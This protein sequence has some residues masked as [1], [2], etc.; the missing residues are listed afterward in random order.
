MSEQIPAHPCFICGLPTEEQTIC[1][2]CQRDPEAFEKYQERMQTLVDKV[3][4]TG[5]IPSLVPPNATGSTYCARHK[6]KYMIKYGCSQC[7]KEGQ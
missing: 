5:E 6:I 7:N 2:A 4:E 3:K 1:L